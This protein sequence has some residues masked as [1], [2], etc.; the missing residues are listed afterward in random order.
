LHERDS[1]DGRPTGSAGDATGGAVS[2][3]YAADVETFMLAGGFGFDSEAAGV[4]A[5]T[6]ETGVERKLRASGLRFTGE[7]GDEAGALDD[8]IG[9]R[10]SDLRGTAVGE[11]FEAANFVDDAFASGGAQLLAEMAGDDEGA[12]RGIEARLG[13][14]D[15]NFSAAARESGGGV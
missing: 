6:E 7:R 1:F 12:G 14:E 3:D 5:E 13:F 11:K 4:V 15:A 8:E 2:A 9:L 10:E